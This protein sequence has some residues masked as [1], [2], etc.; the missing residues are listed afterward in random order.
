MA[1][2][3]INIEEIIYKYTNYTIISVSTH[4]KM[5]K[6]VNSDFGG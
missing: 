4:M 5:S 2:S 1:L 6:N 3:H